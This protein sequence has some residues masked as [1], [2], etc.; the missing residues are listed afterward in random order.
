MYDFT[1]NIPIERFDDVKVQVLIENFDKPL[2]GMCSLNT[3]EEQIT[4][5]ADYD[6]SLWVIDFKE[7]VNLRFV[8]SYL[9]HDHYWNSIGELV[10]VPEKGEWTSYGYK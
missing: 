2:S 1:R 8:P 9:V 7:I 10:H 5:R 4:I 6:D 3:A